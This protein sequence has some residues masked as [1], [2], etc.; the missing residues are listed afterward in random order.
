MY[1]D[2]EDMYQYTDKVEKKAVIDSTSIFKKAIEEER[3]IENEV[4]INYVQVL[5]TELIRNFEKPKVTNINIS[6]C[7]FSC[8][9]E[10]LQW[11]FHNFQHKNFHETAEKLSLIFNCYK[12]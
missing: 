2:L 10:G 8:H 5:Q 7:R 4:Q 12:E 11:P 1:S 3:K 9:W 6:A